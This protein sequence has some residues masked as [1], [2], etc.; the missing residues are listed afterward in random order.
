MIEKSFMLKQVYYT[1]SLKLII[2]DVYPGTEFD[3]TCLSE[4]SLYLQGQRVNIPVQVPRSFRAIHGYKDSP[5]SPAG[6]RYVFSEM[7]GGSSV[8]F[9]KDGTF[10]GNTS[11]YMVGD[12]YYNPETDAVVIKISY[13]GSLNGVGHSINDGDEMFSST[14]Y[15]DYE[16]TERNVDYIIDAELSE[17]SEHM[18]FS[19]TKILGGGSYY[20]YGTSD[21]DYDY[22]VFHK[23]SIPPYWQDSIKYKKKS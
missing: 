23:K 10:V 19:N 8:D 20:R 9:L 17:D 21:Y 16:Y 4:V 22:D 2:D 18:T 7:Y 1:D 15:E 3:D 11:S 14:F 12:W 5:R 6:C 13:L